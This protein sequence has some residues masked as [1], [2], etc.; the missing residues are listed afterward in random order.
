MKRTLCLPGGGADGFFTVGSLKRADELNKLGDNLDLITATS[1][2]G[3][4]GL[5]LSR[6]KGKTD[7][8]INIFESIKSNKDIYKGMLQFNNII[9]DIGMV[10]QILKD[11][12]GVSVLDATPLHK[13]IDREFGNMVMGDLPIRC[14]ITVVNI[15]TGHK[16]IFD[17]QNPLHKNIKVAEVAKA[18]SAMEGIFQGIMIEGNLYGDGGLLRNNPVCYAIDAGATDILLI[19]T[20][21]DSYP[22]KII[23]NKLLPILIRSLEIIMH[24]N[25]ET[26]WDELDQY[27]KLRQYNISLPEIKVTSIYPNDGT[28]LS[29]LNFELKGRIE[30]GYE[31][32]KKILG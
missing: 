28:P 27:N 23:P 11:N 13:L 22:I 1:V 10:S 29:S 12:K 14:I 32:A 16:A 24:E 18:T 31:K 30:A 19:G 9:D 2:G 20:S 4:I 21:A 3:L 26:S 7:K 25:E 15:S 6:D 8:L 5:I 17:S